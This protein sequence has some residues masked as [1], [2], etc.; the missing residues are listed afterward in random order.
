MWRMKSMTTKTR[1]F[2]S[3]W[4]STK[5]VMLSRSKN[6]LLHTLSIL[7]P[8]PALTSP[9]LVALRQ[10][11]I[12][13]AIGPSR[14]GMILICS[15]S[16]RTLSVY[17]FLVWNISLRG[18]WRRSSWIMILRK[19]TGRLSKTLATIWTTF[20]RRRSSSI[21]AQDCAAES[22]ASILTPWLLW[23]FHLGAMVWDM[24]T[25]CSSKRSLT[26]VRS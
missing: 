22:L 15:S 13:F 19:L 3:W 5:V 18:S 9:T 20:T 17:I 24:N 26:L 11:L 14:V 21:S 2:G 25:E 8:W 6:L 1:G 4:A 23:I 7:S 12:V 16:I 10:L